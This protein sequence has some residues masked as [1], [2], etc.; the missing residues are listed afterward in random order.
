M[1]KEQ[2]DQLSL[3]SIRTLSMN[4]VQQANSGHPGTPMAPGNARKVRVQNRH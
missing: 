1:T 3:N 2:M 4:A